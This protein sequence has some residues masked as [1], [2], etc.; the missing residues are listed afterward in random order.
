MP[1]VLR[2]RCFFDLNNNVEIAITF[3]SFVISLSFSSKSPFDSSV[4]SLITIFCL[5]NLHTFQKYYHILNTWMWSR[6]K[7]WFPITIFILSVS[8]SRN[9]TVLVYSMDIFKLQSAKSKPNLY[10]AN[11]NLSPVTCNRKLSPV[12]CIITWSFPNYILL[13]TYKI[14]CADLYYSWYIFL[15]FS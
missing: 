14:I 7:I 13:C 6:F 10:R 2:T 12:T 8:F 3:W 4:E 1:V 15:P 11:C 9:A 5:R